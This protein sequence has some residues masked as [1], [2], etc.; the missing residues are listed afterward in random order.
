MEKI[1]EAMIGTRD[2]LEWEIRKGGYNVFRVTYYNKE[3]L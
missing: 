1:I 3:V 2:Q